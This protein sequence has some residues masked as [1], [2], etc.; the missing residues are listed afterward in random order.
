MNIHEFQAKALFKKYGIQ[1]LPSQVTSSPLEAT[2]I[3]QNIGG[4]EWVVKAQVH[5]G[6]RG[7]GGGI[8]VACSLDEVSK[9]S[10]E[11]L[12]MQLVT[13]QTTKE[14]VPVHK[15][16][17]EQTANIQNEFYLAF[18]VNRSANCISLVISKEGGMDIEEVAEKSPDKVIRINIDSEVSVSQEQKELCA[19]TLDLS[20]EQKQF[21]FHLI[22]QLYKMFLK[23]D[24][25]LLEINPLVL[26]K[27]G[28]LI[29][30]D[31]KVSLDSNA[32]FR[33]PHWKDY[34]LKE[35]LETASAKAEMAGFSFVKLPGTIGCMVNGAGLA[36][37]TM[38]MIQLFGGSPA[39]F[40][41]VGGDA[42]E[43]RI[44]TA[45]GFI[46]EDSRVEGVLVNI[47]GGI[48]RCDLIAEGIIKAA[49]HLKL[50]VPV[51]VR[52]EGNSSEEAKKLLKKSS[53]NLTS[54]S[55]LK[56]ATQTIIQLSQK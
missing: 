27:E 42:D 1:T 41:D 32:A 51:V 44:E 30:L 9:V 15:I 11:I 21:L 54:V 46:L 34:P 26:T 17:I 2:S 4:Q 7:K 20:K 29:P 5:A 16:L 43:R 18:L 36:M 6:G 35:E 23:E 50:T 56:E 24:L 48:V 38:D 12:G 14:G 47:F 28:Q 10:K 37:A 40:L 31:A 8:K 45:F 39:N 33:H 55:D 53:L 49:T 3:A 13:P 52:L 19:K 22:D 25:A